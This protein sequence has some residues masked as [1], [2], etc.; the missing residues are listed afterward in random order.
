MKKIIALI[1]ALT[2][3]IALF[4]CEKEGIESDVKNVASMYA[5]SAPT[6]IVATVKNTVGTRVYEGEHVLVTGKIGDKVATVYTYWYEEIRGVEEG[7]DSEILGPEKTVEGS[8]EY[9][10]DSGLRENGG[11]WDD[12]GY[13][14]APAAG[15]IAINLK[16]SSLIN[17][18]YENNVLTF[19][20][21][22]ANAVDV[23]GVIVGED[24]DENAITENISVTVKNAGSV[25]TGITVAYTIAQTDDYPSVVTTI[26]VVYTYDLE[27]I[28]LTK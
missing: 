8:L 4:S 14:F 5:S 3:S 13:N 28:T 2:C 7:S 10:E 22:P 15:A 20:V 17:P 16:F 6:K 27:K 9:L 26:D 23:L 19:E 11:K 1:L 21:A 18:K 24:L 12:E 25:I